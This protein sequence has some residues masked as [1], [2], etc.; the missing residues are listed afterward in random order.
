MGSNLKALIVG[1]FG[2][3]VIVGLTPTALANPALKGVTGHIDIPEIAGVGNGPKTPGFADGLDF[4]VDP[5]MNGPMNLDEILLRRDWDR[6][7]LQ[8]LRGEFGAPGSPV[9]VP[10]GVGTVPTPGAVGLGV[11]GA[12]LL[13]LRRRRD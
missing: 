4:I 5:E 1:G 8:G 11:I 9:A 13:G 3:A 6:S 12:G 10:D 2:A 7:R